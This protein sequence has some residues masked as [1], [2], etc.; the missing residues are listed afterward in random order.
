MASI[1]K[2]KKTLILTTI[3]TLLP[4]ALGLILWNKLPDQI[5]THFGSNGE[6]DGWSSKA[7]AVLGLPALL[8]AVHL[9]CFFIT[10]ADPKKQRIDPKLFKLILWLCPVISWFGCGSTYAHALDLK[11]NITNIAMVLLGL[12][13]KGKSE[14]LGFWCVGGIVDLESSVLRFRK[15]VHM[16]AD[17]ERKVVLLRY[18]F[19][20]CEI[21]YFFLSLIV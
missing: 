10:L 21:L 7:F 3:L 4:M 6:A 19:S 5:A 13:L 18:F 9:A 11:L 8:A 12:I 16:N 20:G 1:K 14:I 17:K 15:G 2:Y